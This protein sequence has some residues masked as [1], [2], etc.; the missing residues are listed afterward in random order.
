MTNKKKTS[1]K[2]PRRPAGRILPQKPKKPQPKPPP[3]SGA[4]WDDD[5]AFRILMKNSTDI[6]TLLD[7]QGKI[8]YCSPSLGRVINLPDDRVAE[9]GIFEWVWP[10]DAA[11]MKKAF[12][13]VLRS[14]GKGIPFEIRFRNEAGAPRWVEGI[15]TNLLADPSIG[16]VLV[17]YHD[18]TDR[19]R[20]QKDLAESEWKYRE[21]FERATLAI[22]QSTPD[23]KMIRVNP[24]FARMFGYDSP[25]ELCASVKDIAA[26]IFVE[27]SR[28]G[29]LLRRLAEAPA[30][31]RVENLYRRKD[32][33][34]FC[35]SLEIHAVKDSGGR[36]EYLEGFVEDISDR[37][38]AERELRESAERFR[39]IF[40]NSSAGVALVGLDRRYLLINPA[41]CGI[42][43]YSVEELLGSEFLDITHPD[44]VDL[45][46]KAMQEMLN[47]KGKNVRFSKR[48]LHKDGHTVWADVSTALVCDADGK[49]SHFIVH[50]LDMTERRR[51]EEALWKSEGRAGAI[52]ASA[53]Y[54][55]TFVD[56][57]GVIT[58]VNPA[59]ERILGIRQ[60]ETGKRTH[61]DTRWKISAPDGGPFPAERLPFH[62]VMASRKAVYDVEHAIEREN[63]ERALISINSAPLFEPDGTISGMVSTIRDITESRH[64]EEALRESEKRYRS[65]FDNSLEGIA[66]SQ[67]DRLVDG[68]RALMDILKFANLDELRSFSFIDHV[69]PESRQTIREI[70]RETSEG[71]ARKLHFPLKAIRKDGVFV[72]LEIS[73]DHIRLGE[74][75]YTLSSIRDIT[76]RIRTEEELRTL[77]RRY[78][79]LLAAIPEIVMEV[80]DRKVYTWANPAG[81]EFFGADVIGREAASYFEGE[82]NVYADVQP[83]FDGSGETIYVES[84]QRRKDGQKRLLAWWCRNLKND[85]GEV[86]GALSSARDIT[87]QRTAQE[88][89]R[90]LSRFPTENPNPVMRITPEGVLLYANHASRL[91]LEMWNVAVGRT[92]PEDGRALMGEVFLNNANREIE[93]A[94]GGRV[95]ACMLTPIQG[96]GYINVYGRDITERRRA[97][98]SL[99]RQAEELRQRNADLARVNDLNER[100]MRRLIAM[101]AIDTAITSSFKLELVLNI[102]LG[103]LT[104]LLAIPAADVLIF[105]PDLQTFR[106]FC[107][108]GFRNTLP[109]QTFLRK[110]ESY[111]NQAAQAQ[112]IVRVPHLDERAEG[113]KIYP[114]IQGEGFCSYLCIPLLAK[115][116]VKGVLEIFSREHF[117]LD[118]EADSFLELV[119]GQA[120]IAIDNAE[121]FE[122]LQAS[123]DE[124]NLAYNDTLTGWARTLELRERGTAGETQRLAETAVRLAKSLGTNEKDLVA[125]Y[126]G[127]I[128]HDIGM[129]G[130]PDGILGK[131]G[132]LTEEEWTVV[133]KH[134]QFARDLLSSVN[135][136]RP[137]ID[138]PYCHH[139]KWDGSGYPRG[140]SGTEIPWAARIFAVVDV[141]DALRSDRPHRKAWTDADARAYIRQQSGLHFDPKVVEVFF[142]VI[143]GQ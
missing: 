132:P 62:R 17:N 68:N 128:L 119:A 70:V 123:N 105:Q 106:L 19:K 85:R 53:P 55:I 104:D 51:T 35:G 41:F 37:K 8:L 40:K 15:A 86:T 131:A 114:K 107:S 81:I 73:T 4:L 118:P 32:G 135:Y 95:F 52:M 96:A 97:Q 130:I 47:G 60:D 31:S 22:F 110:P 82:Q 56:A 61:D 99:A 42:L 83:L 63:G 26:D 16:A 11:R 5:R 129:M 27:P 46:R 84:W 141:W 66:L 103:Q 30:L 69:A 23:G 94:A 59:A 133:R 112:R 20:E 13:Q 65:L 92:L 91:F 48:F 64:S 67:G 89:I 125:I 29:E 90:N 33:S 57:Q 117:E 127:A 113:A 79:T 143:P 7:A 2:S 34:S 136:L 28:R 45:S 98:E 3:P 39:S 139:E 102:L 88:Q 140:L 58:Y 74:S 1:S 44:D 108:R 43:G 38:R 78:Q 142:E 75:T 121:L 6:F 9:T 109:Q 134:P 18:I 80:D 87:E 122:G 12:A 116:A 72:D 137:A 120:A 138:I 54:G 25:E 36:M 100:Q 49:P 10:D 93:I 50:I 21:L 77:S 126:R 124:L 14:P 24:A 76:E 115:G 111:A 71:R 101:R